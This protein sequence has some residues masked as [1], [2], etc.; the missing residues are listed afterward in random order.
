MLQTDEPGRTLS[1]RRFPYVVNMNLSFFLF[2]FFSGVCCLNYY[3]IY[4]I[5][6]IYM[7]SFFVQ[8][9][10]SCLLNCQSLVSSSRFHW[11]QLEKPANGVAE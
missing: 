3:I 9:S 4:N 6:I 5:Y 8:E 11:G 7:D 2:P 1:Q 10:A